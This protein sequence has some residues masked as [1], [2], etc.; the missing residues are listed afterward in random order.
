MAD[1]E[2]IDIET[3]ELRIFIDRHKATLD[4]RIEDC[5]T[6]ADEL[7]ENSSSINSDRVRDDMRV[8]ESLG[9]KLAAYCRNVVGRRNWTEDQLIPNDEVV[10]EEREVAARTDLTQTLLSLYFPKMLEN[11]K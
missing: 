7:N 10:S 11:T 1:V 5:K 4:N 3:R 9:S 8:M 2:I 6:G